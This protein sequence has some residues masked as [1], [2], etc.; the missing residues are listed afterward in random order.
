MHEP[1]ITVTGHVGAP[2]R[3]R[4]LASGAVVTDFRL[5]CTPRNPDRT[6]VWSD[7]ETL[8]LTVT[9]WKALAENV[10][11]SL[12][13][14]DKV[15]VSGRLKV[16]SWKTEQGE[17]RS[18][19]EV[20]TPTVGFDLSRGTAV[21]AKNTPLTLTTDPGLLVDINTGELLDEPLE[22][23]DPTEDDELD[24]DAISL[25]ERVGAGV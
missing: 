22:E 5:A 10:A 17:L 3:M 18:G 25:D 2:P 8:W 4:V 15:T 1:L 13:K 7:G 6:G 14:G 20:I 12:H 19:L 24:E 11:A 16:S 23:V 9:C 21:L